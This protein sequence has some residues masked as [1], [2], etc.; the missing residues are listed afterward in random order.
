MGSLVPASEAA[1]LI[2]GLLIERYSKRQL[3]IVAGLERHSLRVLTADQRIRLSTR[4]K[5]RR[6]SRILLQDHPI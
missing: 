2:Q 1:R 5:V 4:L 3:A 6:V